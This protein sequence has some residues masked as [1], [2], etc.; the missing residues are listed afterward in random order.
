[1]LEAFLRRL[2]GACLRQGAGCIYQSRF[3]SSRTAGR[4]QNLEVLPTMG[5]ELN[6]KRKAAQAAVHAAAQALAQD[7][8]LEDEGFGLD[9]SGGGP[10]PYMPTLPPG[11]QTS[12]A[13]PQVCISFRAQS[14]KPGAPFVPSL[15]QAPWPGGF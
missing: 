10:A 6:S 7:D 2:K 8:G 3:K 15:P 4:R 11:M 12:A 13:T 1:M 5:S 14:L 9:E